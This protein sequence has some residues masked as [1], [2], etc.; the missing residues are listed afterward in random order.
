MH[1]F[2][3]ELHYHHMKFVPIIQQ[4]I[5]ND[6]CITCGA[7][8]QVCPPKIIRS[9]FNKTRLAYEV[10]ISEPDKCNHCPA[11][12]DK[13]CP[14]ITTN[15]MDLL[16]TGNKQ[17]A[18]EG[19]IEN[20]Y[21]GYSDSEQVNGVS[22][23]G[24]L[25]RVFIKKALLDKDPVICL[26]RQE[27]EYLPEIITELGQ[28]ENIPG[29]IYHSIDYNGALDLII[30]S[31]KPVILIATPCQLAGI[32]NY[33][34]KFNPDLSK[35]IKL[36]IGLICGWSFS[37][38]SIEA[39]K[40]Y[41]GIHDPVID[42]TYRGE[43]QIG[44]L[45]ITTSKEVYTFNRAKPDSFSEWIDYRA[46]FSR[47]LN[48][49]RCRVCQD[50]TNILADIA[51]GDAWLKRT[52]GRKLSIV[53]SRNFKGETAISQLLKNPEVHL[54]KTDVNDVIESQSKNL[55]YGIDAR[56]M[57]SYLISNNIQTPKFIFN[58]KES[59]FQELSK[60]DYSYLKFDFYKKSLVFR[61]KYKKYRTIYMLTSVKVLAIEMYIKWKR[62]ILAKFKN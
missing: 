41:K 29:S 15:F 48:R 4:V 52:R 59:A 45:K 21:I 56:K 39:L 9:V 37:H 23:S 58:G 30:K 26:T 11:P 24:G 18:P 14:S 54:E 51:V 19:P 10:K 49:L 34:T 31:A 62:R 43:D 6:H 57:E 28:I 46:S 27:Q 22:S 16:K 1:T 61:H 3:K 5:D 33:I 32:Q 47:T 55:V 40:L 42:V 36:T 17:V 53:I 60:S 20:V 25:V 35:N 2:G 8:I 38:H 12:C 44:N 13:V 7:C 50:H